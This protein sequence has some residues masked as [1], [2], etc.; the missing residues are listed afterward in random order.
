MSTESARIVSLRSANPRRPAINEQFYVD[1]LC[2]LRQDGWLRAEHSVLV[3]AG[4]AADRDALVAA[5]VR[6]ATIT[7]LDDRMPD[8]GYPP[9]AWSRQ[10]AERLDYADGSF[11]VCIVHQA[12]HHCRSPHRALGEMY[13]VARH[14][15]VVFE[16]HETLM[17]RL[18]VRLGI[19]QRYE[20]AAVADNGVHRGGVQNTDV[21]NFVYR[22]TEREVT[23]T[24]AAYDPAGSPRVRFLY[25]LR[26]PGG[27]AA[28]LRGRTAAMLGRVAAPAARAVLRLAP[29][30][31]NAIAIVADK[32]GPQDLHP[33]LVWGSS[34]ATANR[35]WFDSSRVATS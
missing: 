20:L 13:R 22:W 3:V 2:Q 16:P 26:V 6:A 12:L 14:G 19:G 11:D 27:S 29:S 4:G 18:G 31:A 10:D 30:Q 15:I 28:R 32:L 34:G 17:S 7:N 5:G 25:D 1:T 24:L 33:W 9:Y 8:E 21:P 35:A 23:K